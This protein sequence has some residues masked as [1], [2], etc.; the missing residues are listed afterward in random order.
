MKVFMVT[1]GEYSDYHIL[2]LFSTLKKAEAYIGGHDG[3]EIDER[4]LDGE[5]ENHIATLYFEQWYAKRDG[6]P[7]FPQLD[8][9]PGPVSE[10]EVRLHRGVETITRTDVVSVSYRGEAWGERLSKPGGGYKKWMMDRGVLYWVWA[11][12]A[13]SPEHAHKLA[14]EKYQELL[15]A[16]G[17]GVAGETPTG[18]LGEV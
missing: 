13:V 3:Y 2:G 10:F 4:E 14:V 7:S 18:G 5:G 1:G 8:R 17:A 16:D 11:K 12:S 9:T 6:N 15:R